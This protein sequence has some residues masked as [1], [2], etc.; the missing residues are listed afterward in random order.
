MSYD[1]CLARIERI[2]NG[3]LVEFY[4]PTPRKK[5]KDGMRIGPYVSDWKVYS[6]PT[7]DEALAAM[8]KKLPAVT[9]NADQEYATAF[10]EAAG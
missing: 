9:R 3:F 2:Q 10:D 6:Y 7:L 1:S 5:G 8:K 4:E